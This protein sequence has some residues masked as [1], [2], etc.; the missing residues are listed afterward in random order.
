MYTYS[1]AVKE[2]RAVIQKEVRQRLKWPE[3]CC[4]GQK[5]NVNE[6]IDQWMKRAVLKCV[7]VCVCGVCI[8]I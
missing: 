7:Y 5:K 2:Q 1:F 8:Y 3:I 6:T 4:S